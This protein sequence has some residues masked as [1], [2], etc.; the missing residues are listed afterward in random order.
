MLQLKG[1]I[2]MVFNGILPPPCYHDD[3][4]YAG[5][6][7]LFNHILYER[8]VNKG[9]HL[10]W[11]CLRSREKPCP[12]S[13]NRKNSL[14]NFQ[15]VPPSLPLSIIFLTVSIKTGKSSLITFHTISRSTPKYSCI[16]KFLKSFISCHS[17]S[18]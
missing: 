2:K 18:E 11:G 12:E 9:H 5:I 10:L 7:R 1:D 17:T 6:Y 13:C 3:L 8:L 4:F 14:F 15:C 16:S